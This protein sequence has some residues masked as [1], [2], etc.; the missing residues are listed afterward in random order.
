MSEPIIKFLQ[1][2]RSAGIRVSVAESID[3]YHALDLIGFDDRQTLKDSLALLLAKTR[4]E[5]QLF[6]ECFELYFTRDSFTGSEADDRDSDRNNAP[7]RD[8]NETDNSEGDGS[9]EGGPQGQ[10][11]LARM[12]TGNDRAAL[13][14]A[15]ERAADGVGVSDIRFFTQTNIYARRMMEQMG[16]EALEREIARLRA[17]GT[18]EAVGLA[19]RLDRGRGYLGDQVRDFV[20][21][22]LAVFARGA[23]EQLRDEFLQAARLSNLDRRDFERMRVIVRAMAKRLATRYGRVRRRKRRGHLDVRRTLRRNMAFDSIPF[24][25]VWKQRKIDK[26]R[27]VVLCDVSGSVASVAQF[28]L[29][30]VYSLNEALADI[31]SFAFSGNLVEVS[32]ILEQETIEDAILKILK[33]IGFGS[34]NYGRSLA[35]FAEQCLDAVDSKT[36]VIIMGDARGNNTDPRTDIMKL[37]FE[38]SK[39]VIW[40]NPEFKSSW[41]TGDSDM[42]R[43]GPYCHVL[44]VCNSVRHLERT[45]TDLLKGSNV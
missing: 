23:N 16:L 34:S 6:E 37:I 45:L 7:Q 26:P 22:Q 42:F 13:A 24:I 19:Q 28:L 15:M 30:F 44:T 2:A 38:R 39:R 8:E 9:G 12:L 27:V 33:E 17:E 40:L 1:A 31:R 25:T 5:K 21:R 20:E 3:A 29:L 18:A 4:D 32:D 14:A 43:Y 35:D 36:T 11:P 41:G 10:S